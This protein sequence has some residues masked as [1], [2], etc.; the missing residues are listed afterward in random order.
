[1][2]LKSHIA[3]LFWRRSIGIRANWAVMLLDGGGI[4]ILGDTL[5]SPR[6]K[7]HYSHGPFPESY[8]WVY[9]ETADNLFGG[10]NL[11]HQIWLTQKI[12]GSATTAALH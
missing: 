3:R 4:D 1:M 5:P 8:K 6:V 2:S 9:A 7:E 11:S 10:T 12:G